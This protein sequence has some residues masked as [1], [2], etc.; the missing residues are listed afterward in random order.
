MKKI[1]TILVL[2]IILSSCGVHERCWQET[3]SINNTDKPC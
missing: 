1:L 3:G 2:I